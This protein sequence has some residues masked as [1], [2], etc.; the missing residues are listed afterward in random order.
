M[1]VS[2]IVAVFATAFVLVFAG[3]AY[4]ETADARKGKSHHAQ[5]QG[6]KQIKHHSG[7]RFAGHRQR[8]KLKHGRHIGGYGFHKRGHARAGIHKMYDRNGRKKHVAGIKREYRWKGGKG[9]KIVAFDRRRFGDKG[10]RRFAGNG[11][12]GKHW[13]DKNRHKGS[14]DH[15]DRKDRGKKYAHG[16][17]RH[18][19]GHKHRKYA[20]KKGRGNG[21]DDH[22]HDRKKKYAWWKKK[23]GGH[24]HGG[25]GDDGDGNGRIK[26]IV[27]N[28]NSSNSSSGSGSS[29]ESSSYA[30]MGVMALAML[31]NRD[32]GGGCMTCSGYT[33]AEE[34]QPEAYCE[35]T[36]KIGPNRMRTLKYPIGDERCET[37]QSTKDLSYKDD[38]HSDPHYYGSCDD[39]YVMNSH[40]KCV[41]AM[42]PP[43]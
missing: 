10:K 43:G 3:S 9:A 12:H 39:G 22:G 17:K 11:D 8:F 5:K 37:A 16:H 7:R 24:G 38:E 2:R 40:G 19:G 18:E 1:K 42:P 32:H 20:W 21:H 33:V 30:M 36:E 29:S 26:V 14:R 15:A 41:V 34:R 27:K 31:G 28:Y 13:G 23:K 4:I 6:G 35:V 25:H